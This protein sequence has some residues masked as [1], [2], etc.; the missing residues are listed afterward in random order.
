LVIIVNWIDPADDVVMKASSQA[1]LEWAENE[2]QARGLFHPY[3]YMNYAYGGQPVLERSVDEESLRR[4]WKVKKTYD[5]S[6]ILDELWPGGFK[7][8]KASR[9]QGQVVLDR[10]EL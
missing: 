5:A 7:L 3:V 9:R 1:L 2:A 10:T 6:A 8:P 4:M